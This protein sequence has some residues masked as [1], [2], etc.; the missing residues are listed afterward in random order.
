MITLLVVNYRSA[1]LTA[2][3]IQSARTNTSNPLHVIV[4]DNTCDAR[5]AELLA[6]HAD[7][8][9]VSPSNTGYAGAINAGRPH[10]RGDVV[11]V[12]NPDVVF[13]AGAIDRLAEALVDP[14][15]AVAGPALYWDEGQE[16]ILPPSDAGTLTDKVDAVGGSRLKAWRKWRDGRRFRER[17]AF[18][19]LA[20]T[21]PVRAISGAVMAIRLSDFD[22]IGGF[23]ER[24]PLYFEETDFLR[25][26]ARA[27]RATVYV[28]AARCRHIYNQSAGA[29]QERAALLYAASERAYLSKWYGR[30]LARLLMSL[31]R[32]AEQPRREACSDPVELPRAGLVVEASPLADFSTAAGHFPP[33]TRISL[34]EEVWRSYRAG[35]VYVRAVDK[36]SGETVVSCVRYRS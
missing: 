15:R 33:G 10:C 36:D 9:V 34:P 21:T 5:E 25:R 16:W 14:S 3:A 17:L 30:H 31:D 19:S 7:T 29:D 24:F 18:W 12:S 26:I 20:A 4:V 13:F 35:A 23:D 2:A 11:V 22:E 28:P 1:A 27:G 32:A 6:G 8:L